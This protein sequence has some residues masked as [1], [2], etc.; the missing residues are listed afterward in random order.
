SKKDE[1][2]KTASSDSSIEKNTS[3]TLGRYYC[4]FARMLAAVVFVAGIVLTIK[5]VAEYWREVKNLPEKEIIKYENEKFSS[6]EKILVKLF[7]DAVIMLPAAAGGL[8]L[9]ESITS[10]PDL[11]SGNIELSN[12]QAN[13]RR[14]ITVY[15]EKI[16]K[17]KDAFRKK[18]AGLI[19]P[20]AKVA[21]KFSAVPSGVITIKTGESN[22]AFYDN[23]FMKNQQLD[24]L[25]EWV[26]KAQSTAGNDAKV[27]VLLKHLADASVFIR[28]Q[29][30][31]GGV[32]ELATTV[33]H[34]TSENSNTQGAS[35]QSQAEKNTFSIDFILEGWRLDSQL[36]TMENILDSI[37]SYTAKFERERDKLYKKLTD[38][39]VDIWID[40]VLAAFILLVLAEALRA[41]L[42]IADI[43]R[44]NQKSC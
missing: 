44:R 31:K 15:R 7:S 30:V 13:A 29:L 33:R 18:F 36:K 43:Q 40:T 10:S 27:S 26:K 22:P 4:I 19:A 32:P 5:N 35:P 34:K 39:L 12:R 17:L 37:K 38:K 24:A 20:D 11:M 2:A 8:P 1:S 16:D 25:D 28:R 6:A 21:I 42:D 3:Y 23:L 14:T 9:D 41:L